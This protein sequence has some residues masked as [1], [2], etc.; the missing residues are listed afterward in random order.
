MNRTTHSRRRFLRSMLSLAGSSAVPFTI[1]LAAMGEAAA[2]SSNDY[3]ALICLYMAGGNDGFNTVLATD[4]PSWNAYTSL[5]GADAGGGS[6]VLPPVDAPVGGVLSISPI[7]SQGRTFALHP[8]MEGVQQLF[9]SGRAAIIANVGTLTYPTNLDQYHNNENLPP[10]LFS[11]N[12]QQSI[13]QS[14][15]PEGASLG[16]GGRLGDKVLSGNGAS[17]FTCISASGNAVFLSG[18]DVRQFQ[19]STSGMPPITN[20]NTS[21]FGAQAVANPLKAIVTAQTANGNIFEN[22]Y[23]AVVKRAIDSQQVLSGAMST[24]V[25]APTT[26]INPNTQVAASNPLAL[27]LQTVARIIA[28]RNTLSVKRQVFYVSLGGFDTHDGQKTTQ[29]DLLAKISHAV[30]YLDLALETLGGV[31][32]CSQ[33]TVFTASDFGRTFLSNGDGTDHGWGS[34]HFVFGGAVRGKDIYGVFPV[35]GIG[36]AL[37]VGSGA[38]LPTTSV[39]QYGATLAKWFGVDDTDMSEVF[40]NIGNFPNQTNLGFMR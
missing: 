3:K 15:Q 1:N 21:L 25:P 13:W 39:D 20:L 24:A 27:Q 10:K 31:E 22:D 2:Q 30:T 9:N 29:A 11:H 6:I 18:K 35:T 5:R 19:I 14:G 28:G 33:V 12:D 38:L 37:D 36:H 16:W 8:A 23:A 4:P 17:T 40:P 7:N 34:H 32:L 26:Y